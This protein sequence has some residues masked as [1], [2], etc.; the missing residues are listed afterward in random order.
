MEY[1]EHILKSIKINYKTWIALFSSCLLLYPENL[2][3]GIILY[4]ICILQS[5]WAHR[6]AHE[7]WAFFLN[8]AHIYHHEN[9]DAMSHIVQIGIE[10]L[11]VFSPFI[12]IYFILDIKE[13]IY[14]LDP[15]VFI[16]FYIFYTSTHNVN[17]G[18][19]HVNDVHW[20]HH[21]DYS[22]NYGPDICDIVFKTKYPIDGIENT[23]HYLPNIIIGT[24]IA[25]ACKYFYTNL[26]QYNKEN[27]KKII[28]VLYSLLTAFV[29]F[30]TFKQCFIDISK[31]YNQLHTEFD[32]NIQSI[33]NQLI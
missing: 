9:T 27:T 5:Y 3:L 16:M 11:A 31:H 28:F 1:I 4:I 15:Y 6:V 14:P 33:L 30:Y 18:Q 19:L 20:K 7:Q 21:L 24:V 22:V 23:D 32:N 26:T 8:R 10:T 29:G 13:T 2:F 17:Y 25:L 12:F